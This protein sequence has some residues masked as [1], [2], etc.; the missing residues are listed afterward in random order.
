MLTENKT[1]N[2]TIKLVEK[3]NDTKRK[4]YCIKQNAKMKKRFFGRRAQVCSNWN[5]SGWLTVKSTVG[6]GSAAAVINS[7]CIY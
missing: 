4:I 2:N 3:K 7:R 1:K 6:L 5:E